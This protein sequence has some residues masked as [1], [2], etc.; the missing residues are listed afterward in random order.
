MCRFIE[1]ICCQDGNIPLLDLHQDR[2]DRTFRSYFAGRKALSL[3]DMLKDLPGD[4]KFKCRVSYGA[5]QGSVEYEPYQTP[6][7]HSLKAIADDQIL[8]NYKFE[9]R[10]R[11]SG[12]FRQRGGGGR[13]FNCAKKTNYG[14]LF[15]QCCFL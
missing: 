3:R 2:V 11:L 14:L 6:R 7:V 13:Y 8:Y 15:C 9:D 10:S 1:S 12:L 5:K 4:G